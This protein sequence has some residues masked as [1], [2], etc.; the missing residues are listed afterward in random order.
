MKKIIV[1]VFL[2]STLQSI[3]GQEVPNRI[4]EIREKYGKIMSEKKYF[5]KQV[6]D[7]TW[8]VLEYDEDD[9]K[10]KEKTITYYYD[11][12]QVKMVVIYTTI[13]DD[14]NFYE[15]EI[16]CY[17]DDDSVLFVYLVEKQGFRS[18]SDI[19]FSETEFDTTEKRIYLDKEERCV[20]FLVKEMKCSIET[21]E[22]FQKKTPNVEQ[23]CSDT[24]DVIAEI[25]FLIK[26]WW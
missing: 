5:S 13:Y 11:G 18:L 9:Q 20:R 22:Q 17:L 25:L 10:F 14:Y 4:K 12:S 19:S 15:Q 23:E 24:T 26:K 16:E 3:K 21:I 2:M 6:K 8:D 1:F 7:I